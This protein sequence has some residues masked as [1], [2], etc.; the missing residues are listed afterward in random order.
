MMLIVYFFLGSS[1]AS[2]AMCHALRYSKSKPNTGRSV[3]D[4]CETPLKWWQLFPL[5]GYLLQHGK[6][7]TCHHSISK[8]YPLIEL[9][10]G[11]FFVHLFL[12]YP[13]MIAF[14]H[15][16]LFSW[17]IILAAE[18][19]YTETVDLKLL[20]GGIFLIFSLHLNTI[21]H[22]DHFHLFFWLFTSICLS[23]LSIK[24]LFGWADTCLIS[25][26]I[27]IFPILQVCHIILIASFGAYFLLVI[28]KK[29]T[30]PFIPFILIGLI[31]TTI[32]T[33]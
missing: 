15:L 1:V 24:Y 14:N 23:I 10:I 13:K 25:L 6:C 17:I 12:E 27:L 11:I 29:K 32:F 21:L 33:I 2:F 30:L 20:L 18:D 28:F 22:L 3:C 26:L 4:I 8:L 5:F 7:F 19:F 31:F 16:I 9:F